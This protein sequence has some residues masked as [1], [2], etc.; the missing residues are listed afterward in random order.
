MRTLTI[1][2]LAAAMFMGAFPMQIT[3]AQFDAPYYALEK[4][5]KAEWDKQDKQVD[6]KLAALEKKFG[7]KVVLGTHSY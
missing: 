3:A 4:R 1:A 2:I 6:K 7:I 5:N